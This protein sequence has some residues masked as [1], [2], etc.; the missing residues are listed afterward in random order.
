MEPLFNK[1]ET[2]HKHNLIKSV[3]DTVNSINNDYLKINKNISLDNNNEGHNNFF[4]T[5]IKNNTTANNK[6]IF[7]QIFFLIGF[8]TLDTFEDDDNITLFETTHTKSE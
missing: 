4:F 7:D 1:K 8:D 3:S 5:Y 6:K 2:Y